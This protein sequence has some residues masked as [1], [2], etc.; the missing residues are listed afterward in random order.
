MLNNN[1]ALAG[2]L[3]VRPSR[4]GDSP[5]L[6]A[7]YRS[8]RADLQLIDG[9]DELIESVVAQQF[10]VQQQGAGDAYPDA[11]H[12]VIEKLDTPI[13]ALITDFGHN[14]IRVVYLAFIVAARGRGF[15]RTVLQGVQ[16]AAEQIRCP[17]ATVVWANNPH[18][19]RHYLALGFQIEETN[20]A[21]A[22]LVWYPGQAQLN[23]MLK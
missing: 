1:S 18:A 12:Y 10:Q 8:A 17:V 2:G 7:L 23:T 11:M 4:P 20:P 6:E 22:R 21:A 5:F 9:D 16:Q 13:G 19:L 3:T 15:G 14:E